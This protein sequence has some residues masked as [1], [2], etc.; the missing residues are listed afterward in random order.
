MHS[1]Y[2]GANPQSRF[3]FEIS[4]VQVF[5]FLRQEAGDTPCYFPRDECFSPPGGFMVEKNPVGRK[6]V[7]T[8]AV[9]F[10]HPVGIQLCACIG[11]SGLEIRILIL[12]G[13]GRA[14]ELAARCLVKL[15]MLVAPSG[16][17]EN[18]SRPDSGHISRIFRVS[19]LTLTWLCAPR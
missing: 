19:K 16:R 8:F 5:V 10:G 2:S 15:D 9:I 3:A 6:H 7:I 17:F 14:E 11:T 1:T 12:G 18:P 13:T 4:Q